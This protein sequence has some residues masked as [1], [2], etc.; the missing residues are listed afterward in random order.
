MAY[1]VEFAIQVAERLRP[2]RLRWLEGLLVPNDLRGHIELKQ[3]VPWMPIATGGHVV[4]SQ[5]S[6]FGLEISEDWILPRSTS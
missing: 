6:G 5:A 1:N 3:A 4:P 2:Y